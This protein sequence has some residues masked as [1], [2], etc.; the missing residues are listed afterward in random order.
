MGVAP[1]SRTR[2]VAARHHVHGVEFLR[3]PGDERARARRRGRI[4][5]RRDHSEKRKPSR[6]STARAW[7][8]RRAAR[9][10]ARR[11]IRYD[12]FRRRVRIVAD[13]ASPS[14]VAIFGR[15]ETIP[16][17]VL[18]PSSP[19]SARPRAPPRAPRRSARPFHSALS[20]RRLDV[21]VDATDGSVVVRDELETL[22]ECASTNARPRGNRETRA[23]Y[24]SSTASRCSARCSTPPWR[25]VHRG[26]SSSTRGSGRFGRRRAAHDR[27]A[28]PNRTPQ[29]RP[30][31][32]FRQPPPRGSRTSKATTPRYTRKMSSARIVGEKKKNASGARRSASESSELSDASC[33]AWTLAGAR[34]RRASIAPSSFAARRLERNAASPRRTLA[35]PDPDPP[36][37][38]WFSAGVAESASLEL[39]NQVMLRLIRWFRPRSRDRRRRLRGG[40]IGRDGRRGTRGRGPSRRRR[41]GRRRS[42]G[43]SRFFDPRRDPRAPIR[44]A[45][46]RTSSRLDSTRFRLWSFVVVWR[47]PVRRGSR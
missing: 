36:I 9:A 4:S 26:R 24:P 23:N 3:V 34:V 30:R 25:T 32:R 41:R 42:R 5:N 27:R 12:A 17:G 29:T 28:V 2:L 43:F 18:V 15:T 19:P 39:N 7:C 40:G 46:T 44:S 16:A 1:Q 8:A 35:I 20:A 11:G 38:I 47:K 13:F 45:R 33:L 37:R 14:R 10:H 21:V 22:L 31:R 6:R